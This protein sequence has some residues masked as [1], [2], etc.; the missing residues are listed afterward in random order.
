[1]VSGFLPLG[2]NRWIFTYQRVRLDRQDS[3]SADNQRPPN[4]HIKLAFLQMSGKAGR[5]RADGDN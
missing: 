5:I 3:V 2:H 4:F 1:V